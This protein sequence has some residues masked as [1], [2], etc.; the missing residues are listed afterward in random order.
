MKPLLCGLILILTG[1]LS[2]Q[3]SPHVITFFI[4]PLPVST[5]PA[6]EKALER[7]KKALTSQKILKPPFDKVFNLPLLHAGVYVAYAGTFAHSNADGQILFDRKTADPKLHVLITEDIKPVPIDPLN[8]KTLYGFV[9]AP[10]AQAQQYLIERL[11]DPETDLYEWHVTPEPL[12]KDKRIP[13]DTIIIFA[14]PKHVIV[15][16]GPTATTLNESFILPDF[17]ATEGHNSAANAFQ[18]LK[19][20]HYFAPVSF[21]YKFLPDEYQKKMLP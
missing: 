10:K 21:E 13:I 16:I 3:T 20:R 15:P 1:T 18:F 8:E 6:L 14:N 17:Y 11:K 2:G 4:R 12:S 7:Q 5:T 19:I 9:V